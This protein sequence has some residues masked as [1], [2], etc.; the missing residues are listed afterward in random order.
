[1]SDTWSVTWLPA[2][3]DALVQLRGQGTTDAGGLPVPALSTLDA[4]SVLS[5]L[6]RAALGQLGRLA[7]EGFGPACPAAWIDASKAVLSGNADGYWD[8]NDH[9]DPLGQNLALASDTLD[10]AGYLAGFPSPSGNASMR[11]PT[12][13]TLESEWGP[14]YSG[15]VS[16][17]AEANGY[18]PEGA[19]LGHDKRV[20]S[21][22]TNNQFDEGGQIMEM[23]SL[24]AAH[25]RACD[26]IASG[27]TQSPDMTTAMS[28]NA[29][30]AFWSALVQVG[31]ALDV[32]SDV[33]P[34]PPT[35]EVLKQ[36]ADDAAKFVGDAVATAANAAGRVTAEA[37]QGFAGGI[38]IYGLAAIVGV[39]AVYFAVKV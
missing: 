11:S 24:V 38:G 29:L 14:A 36:L 28:A 12:H 35:A 19:T 8:Q 7:Y 15:F 13:Y 27:A 32:L 26:A 22:Y 30:Q 5:Q 16:N 31:T 21:I 2:A 20:Y 9:F 3:R 1:M 6:T 37:L 39:L 33:P 10:A 34:R 17:E 18:N 4:T 23:R 25:Q